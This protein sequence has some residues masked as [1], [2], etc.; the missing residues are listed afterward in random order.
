MDIHKRHNIH[1]QSLATSVDL[2]AVVKSSAKAALQ[3]NRDYTAKT[4]TS[5]FQKSI[6]NI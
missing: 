2:P 6:K 5:T 1:P 3:V 4:L